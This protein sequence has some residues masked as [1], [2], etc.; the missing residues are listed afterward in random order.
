MMA[1]YVEKLLKYGETPKE[2]KSISMDFLQEN[3]FE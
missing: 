3:G 2:K 1:K